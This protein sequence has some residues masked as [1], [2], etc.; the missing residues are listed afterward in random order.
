MIMHSYQLTVSIVLYKND[1]SIKKLIDAVLHTSLHS[2]LY[3]VDNSPT[4]DIEEKMGEY[5]SHQNVQYI[6][7]GKNLGY[8]AAHNIALQKAFGKSKYHLIINPDIFFE[9]GTLEKIYAFMEANKQVSQLMPKIIYPNGNIQR[10]CKL[11]PTPFDLIGRRFF[12]NNFRWVNNRNSHYELNSFH[13]DKKY[14]IRPIFQDVLC[15]CARKHCKKNSR[16]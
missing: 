6:F 1:E 3:L 15:L 4:R 14:L 7:T 5:L 9:E 11:L 10:L 12:G 2:F 8:G 13:Y 16:L